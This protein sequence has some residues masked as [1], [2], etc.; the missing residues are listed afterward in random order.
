MEKSATISVNTQEALEMLSP[1]K[2][3]KALIL[4]NRAL[5]KMA[6]TAI[7]REIVS[8]YNLKSSYVNKALTMKLP[9]DSNPSGW[10]RGSS[11]PVRLT[12]F[13]GTKEVAT[14][15]SVEVI[16]GGRV[17]IEDAFI[18]M[19]SG[20]DYS[21]RGQT[22][23]V[24]GNTYMVFKQITGKDKKGMAYKIERPEKIPGDDKYTFSIGKYI[25]SKPAH[26]T[27]VRIINQF[28]PKELE[29]NIT[30]MLTGKRKF[31]DVG[32]GAE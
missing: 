19:P 10:L 15:V 1:R 11:K 5:T 6:R 16:K 27:I 17:I 30:Y 24:S 20:K 18:A 23:P 21:S 12:A 7:K 22:K 25:A 32:N 4:T 14:G 26:N 31:T 13:P 2:Q 29:S 8:R 3:R 9:S 28:G